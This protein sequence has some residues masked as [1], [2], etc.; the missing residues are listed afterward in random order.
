M[1]KIWN[2]LCGLKGVEVGARGKQVLPQY[3][4]VF[5]A[6]LRGDQFPTPKMFKYKK[7]IQAHQLLSNLASHQNHI[8]S[9]KRIDYQAPQLD[10]LLP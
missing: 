8:R 5:R 3:K 4:N 6:A 2:G 7:D 1:K 9:L 10:S